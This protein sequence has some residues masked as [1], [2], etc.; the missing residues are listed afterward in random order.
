MEKVRAALK[1]IEETKKVVEGEREVKIK[2]KFKEIYG[3]EPDSVEWKREFGLN[4]YL[5]A[6]ACLEIDNDGDEWRIAGQE[7]R[8]VIFILREDNPT[9]EDI[10]WEFNF[11]SRGQYNVFRWKK[12]F[13]NYFAKVELL[14]L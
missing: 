1:F 3:F 6:L 11:Y 5:E 10:N 9:S 12:N 13:K 4:F 8:K 2:E 14:T 7:V